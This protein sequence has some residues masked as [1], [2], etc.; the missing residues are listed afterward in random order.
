VEAMVVLFLFSSFPFLLSFIFIILFFFIF[1][2][3]PYFSSFFFT[4]KFSN[5]SYLRSISSFTPEIRV[6]ISELD[7]ET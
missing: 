5:L 4:L 2:Y 6:N 1:P 3:F 7:F